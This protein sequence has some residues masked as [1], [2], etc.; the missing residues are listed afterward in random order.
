[1]WINKVCFISYISIAIAGFS[2]RIVC[3]YFSDS[4]LVERLEDH[5]RGQL[6]ED[7]QKFEG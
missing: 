2:Y 4:T 1:M 3:R 7:T 6:F 5:K